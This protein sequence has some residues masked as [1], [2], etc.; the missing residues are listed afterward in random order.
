VAD[1]KRWAKKNMEFYPEVQSRWCFSLAC[2]LVSLGVFL[3]DRQRWPDEPNFVT[4]VALALSLIAAVI[5]A[6]SVL[7][8]E[9]R[10]GFAIVGIALSFAPWLVIGLTA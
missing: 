3:A 1:L 5:G 4:V 7:A 10:R 8:K 6:L 9:K 2:G